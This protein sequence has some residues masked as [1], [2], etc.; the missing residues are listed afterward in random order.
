[1]KSVGLA[2]AIAV[3]IDATLV[4]ALIVPATMRLLGGAELV[5][6]PPAGA[7]PPPPGAERRGRLKGLTNGPVSY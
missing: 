2:M 4:R 5:G 7:L 6:A 1:V 3:A